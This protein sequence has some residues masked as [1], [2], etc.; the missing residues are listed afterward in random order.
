M[1]TS[2]GLA[3]KET[4]Q[5][6][7]LR[8]HAMRVLTRRR[9]IEQLMTPATWLL[10]TFGL[11]LVFLLVQAFVKS[12][13]SSGFDFSLNPL[14]QIIY[15][16]I[17]SA[18]G[19]TYVRQ[20]FADGPFAFSLSVGFAPI[21][22]Y[23][24]LTSIQR[25]GYER[26]SGMVDLV[27]AGPADEPAY[28]FSFGAADVM[29]AAAQLILMGLFLA[30]CGMVWNMAT[31]LPVLMYL[32]GLLFFAVSLLGL[33]LLFGA[34]LPQP[35]SALALFLLALAILA[36]ADIAS[37]TVVGGG[38]RSVANT[39]SWALR[40]LSPFYYLDMGQM[41]VRSGHGSQFLAALF[42]QASLCVAFVLGGHMAARSRGGR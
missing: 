23:L 15:G 8:L 37:F 7:F 6:T 17:G 42:G 25:F 35:A 24:S 36:Y 27:A 39:A 3:D 31:G 1:K 9:L 10:A 28:L 18:F 14:Y 21:I 41:A 2:H 26:R 40:W 29:V 12:V 22:L 38:F 34:I 11:I 16:I 32:L 30:L 5:N 4:R 20:M 19:V 33:A 13:D